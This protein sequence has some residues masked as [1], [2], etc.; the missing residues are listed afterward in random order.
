M[1]EAFV[2]RVRDRFVTRTSG[3]GLLTMTDSRFAAG[4]VGTFQTSIRSPF[5]TR[6]RGGE[7]MGDRRTCAKDDGT[8]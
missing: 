8:G 3:D 6:P 7:S 5:W 4:P 2:L 1:A